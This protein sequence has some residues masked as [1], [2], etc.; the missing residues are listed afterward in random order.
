MGGDRCGDG[1][2]APVQRSAKAALV[3]CIVI[4]V[5][6]AVGFWYLVLRDDA[7]PPPRIEAT[8]GSVPGS[9]P[10]GIDGTWSIAAGRGDA[11][12]GYRISE[13]FAA[14]TVKKEAVGRTS[15]IEG[16]MT[17]DGAVITSAQV[18]ADLSR[19]ES[20]QAQRDRALRDLGLE[21]DRFPTATFT[22]TEPIVLPGAPVVGETV[23]VEAMGEL[24]LHGV[25]RPVTLALQAVWRGPTIEVAGTAPV[26]LA[27]FA[28]AR[29][30]VPLVAV[31]DAGMLEV[32][33]VFDAPAA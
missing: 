22:L 23:D 13:L 3:A 18:T 6:G 17:V 4:V 32:Q 31:D 21:T 33:L 15:A 19:L 8:V 1:L 2:I 12:V 14:D 24:E 7:P 26:R 16:S 29:V 27:D 5:G 20:E 25:T 10:D 28:I 30:S 9:I 11:Y